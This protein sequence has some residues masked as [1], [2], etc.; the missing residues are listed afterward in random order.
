MKLYYFD[1]KS[2][3]HQIGNFGDDL[4]PWL[5]DR[6]LPDVLDRNDDTLFVGIGT[7]LNERLHR[8]F[9][10]AFKVVFGSGVGYGESPIVDSSWKIYFVRGLLSAKALEIDSTFA[11]TDPAILVRNFYTPSEQKTFSWSYMPH[12]HEAIFNG[13]IWQEICESLGIRYISPTAPIEQ[14]LSDIDRSEVLLTEAMHGAIVADAIRVPWVAVKTKKDIL[15]FKW[16]DWL[17]TVSLSYSPFTIQRFAS[18]PGKEGVLR[19]CDYQLIR[20]QMAYLKQAAKPQ[21]SSVSKQNE[22]TEKV[23]LKLEQ[24]KLDRVNQACV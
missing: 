22:L 12:Y 21:L 19:Y 4:N 5:W 2:R 11:L 3:E 6:L 18:R 15:D 7:L 23:M 8:R 9:P 17:S 20:M 14:I 16:H 13:A 24:F 10:N 1:G